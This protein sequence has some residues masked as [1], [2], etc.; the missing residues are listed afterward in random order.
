[1]TAPANEIESPQV[2]PP[3]LSTC[4]SPATGQSSSVY[5]R[6]MPVICRNFFP[7]LSCPS[8]AY[9]S[10]SLLI[11]RLSQFD[12]WWKQEMK[13]NFSHSVKCV[14]K[15]LYC[16]V[17]TQWTYLSL[18]GSHL[19][20]KFFKAQSIFLFMR[21]DPQWPKVRLPPHVL[22]DWD[23]KLTHSSYNPTQNLHWISITH[24][25][26]RNFL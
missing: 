9:K 6:I 18:L 10:A 13:G 15:L 26:L 8:T 5:L 22:Q 4:F 24:Q 14:L 17:T 19:E 25:V 7:S 12:V 1:M 16:L 11:C 3:P 2:T 21:W 23:P 20:G